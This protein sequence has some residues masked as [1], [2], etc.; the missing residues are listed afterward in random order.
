VASD[1]APDHFV[2]EFGARHDERGETTT[3]KAKPAKGDHNDEL[4]QL[5]TQ[6]G[7]SGR[8][9]SSRLILEIDIR[10]RLSAVVAHD[11]AGGL[12]LDRQGG[13]KRRL[14]MAT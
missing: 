11:E 4:Q 14:G 1:T 9:P 12:L 8:R 5:I 2:S 7:S 10:E 3:T 13:G 6:R